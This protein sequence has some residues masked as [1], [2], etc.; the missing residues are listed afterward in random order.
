MAINRNKYEIV[1]PLA[2]SVTPHAVSDI[3]EL[4]K[5]RYIALQAFSDAA[6]VAASG[7]ITSN[8][9]NVSNNDTVT[10]GSKT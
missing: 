9:T 8:N 7:T 5:F 6:A 4:S 2:A 1:T 10:I 3:Y